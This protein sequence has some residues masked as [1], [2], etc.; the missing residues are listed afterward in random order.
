[1]SPTSSCISFSTYM[2]CVWTHDISQYRRN[3]CQGFKISKMT[4][5]TVSLTIL[6]SLW[7]HL[8]FA[9]SCRL[10]HVVWSYL[11]PLL[12]ARKVTVPISLV[13]NPF[14]V[15]FCS[16]V[17]IYLC[18]RFLVSPWIHEVFIAT[19]PVCEVCDGTNLNFRGLFM[20]YD[21]FVSDVIGHPIH[22]TTY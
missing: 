14:R 21:P 11:P 22:R 4:R 9:C 17:R 5:S 15:A 6:G 7:W 12:F 8:I 3:I 16:L 13:E 1:M 18:S 19:T 2:W 20:W 10:V